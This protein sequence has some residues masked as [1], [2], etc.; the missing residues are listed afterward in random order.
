M[1]DDITGIIIVAIAVLGPVWITFHYINRGQRS[2]QVSTQDAAAYQQLAATAAR[3]EA[4]MATLER[5][6]DAEVPDWR[7]TNSMGAEYRGTMG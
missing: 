2:R 4:R 1:M 7:Q 3:M 5:I 6:L